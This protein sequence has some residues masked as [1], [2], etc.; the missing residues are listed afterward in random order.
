[1]SVDREVPRPPHC[2]SQDRAPGAK[3]VDEALEHVLAIAAALMTLAA[4]RRQDPTLS[5]VRWT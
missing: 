2:G 5:G 3:V 4:N 1:M